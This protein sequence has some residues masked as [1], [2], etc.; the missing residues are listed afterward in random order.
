M[1]SS[2]LQQRDSYH[3]HPYMFHDPLSLSAQYAAHPSRHHTTCNPATAHQQAHAQHGNYATPG[4]AGAG[5]NVN[6]STSSTGE[7][8]RL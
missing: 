6:N 3:H 2:C 1:S 5:N 7:I 8:H 4:S